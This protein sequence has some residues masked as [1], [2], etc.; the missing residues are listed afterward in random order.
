MEGG[1]I[2]AAFGDPHHGGMI[3]LHRHASVAM[4]NDDPAGPDDFALRLERD[5]LVV[6]S[7]ELF[8]LEAD[9]LDLVSPRHSDGRRTSA[10]AP[11]AGCV[12]RRPT[13]RPSGGWRR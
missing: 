8:R 9:E 2:M 12:A 11:R 7:G 6:L 10:S 13:P 1:G 5:G 4:D 3:G